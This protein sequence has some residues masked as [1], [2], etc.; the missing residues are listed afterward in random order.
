MPP[1]TAT[2]RRSPAWK[3]SSRRMWASKSFASSCTGTWY[4][5]IC[6]RRR[7]S[8]AGQPRAAVPTFSLLAFP[9]SHLLRL[10]QRC[11]LFRDE[12]LNFFD[13]VGGGHVFGFFFAAGAY[14]YFAG[15]GFFVSDY[16][17]ERDFLHGVFADLGV[18]LLVAC[19]HLDA[20]TD[21]FE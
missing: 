10:L 6:M 11:S 14:V 3:S 7:A 5:A 2:P 20:H 16:Q 18:H 17:E 19:V 12:F 9:L 21:G 15:L 1:E 13:E 4:N 8:L